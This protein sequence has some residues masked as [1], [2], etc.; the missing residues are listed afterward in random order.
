MPKKRPWN[1]TRVSEV[2]GITFPILLGPFGGGM[3]SV[4]LAAAVSNTGGLGSFGVN[5][6]APEGITELVRELAS[7]TPNPFNINLWVPL[8][9]ERE[10][11]L[12][13]TQL[14]ESAQRLSPYATLLGIAPGA[15]PPQSF[16]DFDEQLAALLAARPP[17]I[18]FVFGVPSPSALLEARARSIVTI[19]TATTVDEAVVLDEAGI[20]IIVASGSDAGG[21][22]GAFLCD[23]DESLVGTMS[24]VPQVVDAVSA[25]VVAAG[26]IAD[27]RQVQAAFALGA[28]GVQIGTA[29]LVT[30]ESTASAVH[31]DV[32]KSARARTTVL[33]SVFTGRAARAVPNE[34]T[35]G[36]KGV[37]SEL[38]GYPLQS[39]LTLP[40]RRAATSKGNPEFVNLWA[41]QS[42]VLAPSG[43]AV[44]Y[45]RRLVDAVDE[46]SPNER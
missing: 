2:L 28:E 36:L 38:P 8:P 16:P 12:S 44:D 30:S 3:S 11:E 26:G 39:G 37:E 33:T 29:F 19:A 14:E 45:L 25:P 5:Y 21:H 32:L 24:L 18:S 34:M 35:R 9:G 40:I 4:T 42:A 6:L 20:D 43:S 27:H 23:V 46:V 41:G 10:A 7:M 13:A 31:K 22:R 15:A 1:N 17:V